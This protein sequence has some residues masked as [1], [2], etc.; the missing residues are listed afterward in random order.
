MGK[1]I[2]TYEQALAKPSRTIWPGCGDGRRKPCGRVH[3][4]GYS[5]YGP[6][7]TR[8]WVHNFCCWQNHEHGCPSPIPPDNSGDTYGK[9]E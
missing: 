1:R 3:D 8:P 5:T 6:N 2:T 7:G 9:T 4:F